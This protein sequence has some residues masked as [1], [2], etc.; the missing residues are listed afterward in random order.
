MLKNG[1]LN[2]FLNLNY[3]FFI[4]AYHSIL[5]ETEPFLKTPWSKRW[6]FFLISGAVAFQD[7]AGSETLPTTYRGFNFILIRSETSV[8]R[9]VGWLVCLS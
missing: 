3:S 2:L 5:K 1:F 6:R 4:E 8:S 7:L 9:W